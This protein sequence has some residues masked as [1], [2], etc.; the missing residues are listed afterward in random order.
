MTLAT[1][2]LPDG[3]LAVLG[4][5]GRPHVNDPRVHVIARVRLLGRVHDV[6]FASFSIQAECQARLSLLQESF[7]SL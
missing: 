3:S 6:S 1:A 7:M 2:L 4:K 5:E